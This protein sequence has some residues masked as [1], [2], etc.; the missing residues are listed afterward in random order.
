M[1]QLLFL[2]GVQPVSLLYMS[3]I[4]RSFINLPMTEG[5]TMSCQESFASLKLP[6]HFIYSSLWNKPLTKNQNIFVFFNRRRKTG[7]S[8]SLINEIPVL[9]DSLCCVF[10]W[11]PKDDGN[12]SFCMQ[13]MKEI[14]I[15]EDNAI[16]DRTDTSL[17]CGKLPEVNLNE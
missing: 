15:P 13:C 17:A 3:P 1:G 8:T 10:I 11:Q 14:G 4:W 6:W 7:I 16:S 2:K 9:F 5:I 12:V